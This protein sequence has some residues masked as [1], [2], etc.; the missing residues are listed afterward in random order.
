MIEYKKPTQKMFCV[1]FVLSG[2]SE[3]RTRETLLAFTRFPGVPL[4][5]LEHLSFLCG[6]KVTFF[7]LFSKLSSILF[8]RGIYSVDLFIECNKKSNSLFLT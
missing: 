7:S 8:L 1:G 2:K 3:I 4:Q 5:P 6:C